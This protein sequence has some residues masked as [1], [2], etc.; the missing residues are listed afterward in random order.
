MPDYQYSKSIPPLILGAIIS[1]IFAVL[2][3]KVDLIVPLVI[4]ALVVIG[5]MVG[6]DARAKHFKSWDT[7]TFSKWEDAFPRPAWGGIKIENDTTADLKECEAEL[8]DYRSDFEIRHGMPSILGYMTKTDDG[9]LYWLEKGEFVT[10]ANIGRGKESFI[11]VAFGVEEHEKNKQ[12]PKPNW[13]YQITT[14]KRTSYHPFDS[15]YVWVRI[16]GKIK[17]EPL[18]PIIKR[19]RLEVVENTFYIKEIGDDK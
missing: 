1:A 6:L 18:D 17:D 2:G 14:T 16:S 12:V 11:V 8:M 7:V 13:I 5:V 3:G 10:S 4:V 9:V 15:G 19:V